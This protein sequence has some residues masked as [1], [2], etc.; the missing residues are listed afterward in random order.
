MTQY[1]KFK[2]LEE[3]TGFSKV[4]FFVGA[5]LTIGLMIYVI[6]G[7]KLVSDLFGFVYPAYM[8][9]KALDGGKT[10]DGDATQCLTYWIIFCFMNLSEGTFPFVA[11]TVRFFYLFKIGIIIYLYHPETS[12]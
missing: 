6:G 11:R 5:L 10:V 1:E 7:M 3:K 12:G 8:S 9:L 4:Y 2:E